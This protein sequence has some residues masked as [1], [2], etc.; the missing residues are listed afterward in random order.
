LV[1]DLDPKIDPASVGSFEPVKGMIRAL[2]FHNIVILDMHYSRSDGIYRQAV[3]G[4]RA[5]HRPARHA[6]T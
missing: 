2:L 6:P 4:S 5:C 1:V 3:V